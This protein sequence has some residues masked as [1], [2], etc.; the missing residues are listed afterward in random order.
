MG[1]RWASA[2]TASRTNEPQI[3]AFYSFKGGGG[4]SMAVLN[5]A[6]ALAGKGRRVL[7]LDMDLEAP[8]INGCLHRE[9]E[10]A[11]FARRDMVDLVGQAFSAP[12]ATRSTHTPA[13]HGV[14]R[15][16]L[17]REAA[18]HSAPV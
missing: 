5:L 7:V 9:K 1:S 4:R 11:G 12:L 17:V 18:K 16:D 15:A 6:F 14:C 10:I 2:V 8:G 13:G 3:I